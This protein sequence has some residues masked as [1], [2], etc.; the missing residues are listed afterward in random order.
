MRARG[1]VILFKGN[2]RNHKV[3][4]IYAERFHFYD[5]ND[6]DRLSPEEF[7]GLA[8]KPESVFVNIDVDKDGKLTKEE[9]CAVYDDMAICEK[10]FIHYD[11]D[12]DGYIILQ[13]FKVVFK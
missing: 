10:R 13:E 5:R 12:G 1:L 6:D 2:V 3:V 4:D 8:D 7:V 9:L 11:R